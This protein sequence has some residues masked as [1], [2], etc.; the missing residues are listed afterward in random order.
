LD[1][2]DNSLIEVRYIYKHMILYSPYAYKKSEGAQ[3]KWKEIIV[4][5]FIY[6]L[7]IAAKAP[8]INDHV[9]SNTSSV[10]T[11]DPKI[12]NTE[13]SKVHRT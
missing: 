8:D 9:S 13:L 4:S 7:F 6:S 3:L 12:P 11:N 5:W 1:T 2:N 10:T